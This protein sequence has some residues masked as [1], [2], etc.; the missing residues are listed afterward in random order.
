M[1]ESGLASSI[2]RVVPTL[3][4]L[5]LLAR[6]QE[7]GGRKV[8]FG[9]RV[10]QAKSLCTDRANCQFGYT[11]DGQLR[12]NAIPGSEGSDFREIVFIPPT[13]SPDTGSRRQENQGSRPED[14]FNNQNNI[15]ATQKS[16]RRRRLRLNI[17]PRRRTQESRVDTT[18]EL[19]KV[20]STG[21]RSRVTPV[22][23][24][25]SV[26]RKDPVPDRTKQ[27]RNRKVPQ[28]QWSFDLFEPPFPED[29]NTVT[30][31]IG[32][33]PIV[34]PDFDLSPQNRGQQVSSV[35]TQNRNTKP[36]TPQLNRQAANSQNQIRNRNQQKAKNGRSQG[37]RNKQAT[38]Q[39]NTTQR[40]TTQQRTTPRTAAPNTFATTL[41]S[42]NTLLEERE[43]FRSFNN[44]TPALQAITQ[45][46][47]KQISNRRKQ[48]SRTNTQTT[49]KQIPTTTPQPETTTPRRRNQP[50]KLRN[51]SQNRNNPPRRPSPKPQ[52]PKP[53]ENKSV[54]TD[55]CPGTLEECVDTCVPLED[56][57]AYSACVVECGERC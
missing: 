1:G 24:T 30:I 9:A 22:P 49:R 25:K 50:K 28:P 3:M 19:T 34:I 35:I 14:K 5:A 39:I 23:T 33:T 55:L 54:G 41:T 7:L 27:V 48:S 57:Y 21:S 38:K 29:E 44:F 2:M 56:I 20:R 53:S 15:P 46:P 47:S 11:F 37:Q 8:K 40:P 42:F 45:R 17:D 43:S 10:Q 6:S 52:S 32:G 36:N 26:N 51:K 13:A 12:E 18:T 4:T 31:N 16:P